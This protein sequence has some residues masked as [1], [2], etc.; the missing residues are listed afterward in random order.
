MTRFALAAALS[1]AATLVGAALGSRGCQPEPEP[2]EVIALP[3]VVEVD[4]RDFEGR[5][6]ALIDQFAE[7]VVTLDECPEN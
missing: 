1:L 4:P 5:A 3:A 7:L 2:V 6:L